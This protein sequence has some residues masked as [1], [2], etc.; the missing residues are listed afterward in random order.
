MKHGTACSP[1]KILYVGA[2]SQES[3][4]KLGFPGKEV[5]QGADV[6]S[7]SGGHTESS[8]RGTWVEGWGMWLPGPMAPAQVA[9]GPFEVG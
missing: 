4:G 6:E 9:P 3:K 1:S 7:N 8:S 5:E 2:C